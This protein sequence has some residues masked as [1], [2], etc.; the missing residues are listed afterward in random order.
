MKKKIWGTL[1]PFY[2]P[3]PFLGRIVA[4][5][6]FLN[7]L[8]RLDP[9]DEYHFFVS[10]EK[11]AFHCQ[12]Y[13]RKKFK[14]TLSKIS[15]FPRINLIQNISAHPYHVFHLSDCINYPAHLARLRNKY[16]ERIFPVT[17]VTHS[18]SYSNYSHMLLKQLWPGWSVRDAIVCSSDCG[19]QVLKKYF[20]NLRI[21]YGLDNRFMPPLLKHIP[22]GIDSG[23]NHGG[24]SI[25]STE[26]FIPDD[27]INILCFGR[28]SCYSK[29]DLL[30]ILKSFQLAKIYG[31]DTNAVRLILA[32]G[33][34]QKDDTIKKL[35]LFAK[36]IG[37]ELEIIPNPDEQT[38]ELL[39]RDTHIFLSM[40]DNPQETFGLT[41][42]EAQ[43]AGLPV[44]ASDY[45]G[46]RELIAHNENGLLIPTLGPDRTE[47]IDDLAPLI[48]DSESHLLLAQSCGFDLHVL[49]KTLIRLI[50]EPGL[51]K[52]IGD[53][54]KANASQ[55]T[56]D[57]IIQSY[58]SFWEELNNLDELKPLKDQKHPVH[59]SYSD[60][61]S[62][63]TTDCWINSVVSLSKLG[64][65]VYR[66]KDHLVIYSGL[67]HFID[68]EKI[69][70]LLFLSRAPIKT[71]ILIARLCATLDL[72]QDISRLIISWAIKQGL[73]QTS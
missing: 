13:F 54:G 49:A 38:K 44:I 28:I 20:D 67:S 59:T 30:P 47:Y 29:M 60:I 11:I 36:N 6:G 71:P 15:F 57:K 51:R 46:Y 72:D 26:K 33:V 43:S 68:K 23:K 69:R 32:G 55:Y 9:Y 14:T 2:E 21:E 65:A 48:F 8:L 50:A 31:L 45:N 12:N 70:M 25:Q 66:E 41:I 24:K 7:A 40:S 64:R 37:V 52:A 35:L 18:L 56:W 22:L 16:S 4:N 53:N 19:R 61:F 1:D 42:L 34:D 63:Y 3:G 27:K 73:L 17:S 10:S 62:H 5:T 58:I 39:L